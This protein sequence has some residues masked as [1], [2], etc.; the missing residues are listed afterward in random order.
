MVHNALLHELYVEFGIEGYNTKINPHYRIV[1]FMLSPYKGYFTVRTALK[2]I[3]S[4]HL[5]ST[6]SKQHAQKITYALLTSPS[7]L[8][9]QTS[10]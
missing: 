10:Q 3:L 2:T 7:F 4:R 5:P 9:I 6:V 8:R 1:P